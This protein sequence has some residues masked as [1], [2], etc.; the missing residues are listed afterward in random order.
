MRILFETFARRMADV[1]V[2]DGRYFQI[3]AV[4]GENFESTDLVQQAI[5]SILERIEIDAVHCE[6]ELLR[7]EGDGQFELFLH[8]EGETARTFFVSSFKTKCDKNWMNNS[9]W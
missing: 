2:I 8:F 5:R 6:H 9:D 3:Q 7:C 4:V 1:D